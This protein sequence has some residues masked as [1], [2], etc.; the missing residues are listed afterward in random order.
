MRCFDAA[1]KPLRNLIAAAVS[2]Q[3]ENIIMTTISQMYCIYIH[4]HGSI[5]IHRYHYCIRMCNHQAES[6]IYPCQLHLAFISSC[7]CH[8]EC[9]HNQQG[10]A[11]RTHVRHRQLYRH[12]KCLQ[13]R[14]TLTALTPIYNQ[15]VTHNL[16]VA[17]RKNKDI[18]N[19][20]THVLKP[21]CKIIRIQKCH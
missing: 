10:G 11:P 3:L 17:I 20:V 5:G 1:I 9:L 15:T 19:N 8:I 7:Y 4:I 12:R 16:L 18:R 13:Y 2:I 21:H 14:C 6:S